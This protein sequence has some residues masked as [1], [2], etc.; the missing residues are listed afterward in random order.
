MPI[1]MTV[2]QIMIKIDIAVLYILN[3]QKGNKTIP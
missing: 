3:D 1:A 2:P